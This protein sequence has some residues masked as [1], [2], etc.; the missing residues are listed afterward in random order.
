MAYL[1]RVISDSLSTT[2]TFALADS[3]YTPP[4][5]EGFENAI[6]SSTGSTIVTGIGS[7]L[8]NSAGSSTGIAVVTGVSEVASSSIPLSFDDSRFSG[9]TDH[10]GSVTIP[11]GG[12]I[13]NRSYTGNASLSSTIMCGA[14]VT[15]TNCRVDSDECVRIGSGSITI[16]ECYLE[17]TGVGEDHADVIQAYAPGATG[18]LILT[19]S[20]IV[21]HLTAATAG[22]F[23]A[24]GWSG[25]VTLENVAFIGGP[26]GCRIYSD[27][28]CT[29][30]VSFEDVYFI[31]PFGSGTLIIEPYG[32]GTLN[33]TNWVN[34]CEATIVDGVIVPGNAIASP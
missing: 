15:I 11:D 29:V 32:G 8:V 26:Y 27:P 23:I 30:N 18:A 33:I 17:A 2:L 7:S 19:N 12:S 6:G 5:E 20:C 10:T 16:D 4:E 22:L 21:S 3:N 31:G 14:N 25:N 13:S 1:T 28:G 9:N 24:D 34:V